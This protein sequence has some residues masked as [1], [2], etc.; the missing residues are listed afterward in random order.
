MTVP[1]IDNRV[2]YSGNGST[3]VFNYPYGFV[4]TSDIRVYLVESDG[5]TAT[6]QV[7]PTH[8]SVGTPSESGADVTMV[9]APAS[10]QDLII[11]RDPTLTQLTDYT[12]N[13]PFPANTHEAALDKRAQVE[14]RTRELIGAAFRVA[15]PFIITEIVPTPS[16]LIGFDSTGT[17]ITTYSLT[18]W[19]QVEVTDATYTLVAADLENTGIYGN[20]GSSQTFTIPAN[21]SVSAADAGK[22]VLF[23]REGAG[24]VT[25]QVP[26]GV[27]LN[28]TDNGSISISG[29]YGGCVAHCR[30]RD[31][32]IVSGW[33]A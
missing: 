18:S 4:A 8:Y 5:I 19:R 13:D 6:L 12:D 24:A 15:D 17:D 21:S 10:G 9:T 25:I 33:V 11:F 2:T 26:A 16:V 3:T 22:A 20:S 27:T 1:S 31:E 28:G 14:I 30:V 7:S 29:Q 32:W 23:F